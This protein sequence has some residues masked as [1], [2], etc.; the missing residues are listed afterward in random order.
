MHKP[1]PSSRSAVNPQAMWNRG[2][3]RVLRRKAIN[4]R[5]VCRLR[6]PHGGRH[7]RESS[8]D[9]KHTWHNPVQSSPEPYHTH[10]QP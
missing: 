8:H 5:H 7:A 2:R 1:N 3:T 4:F 10:R 6:V 9:S